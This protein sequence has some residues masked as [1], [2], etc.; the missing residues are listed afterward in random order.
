MRNRIWLNIDDIVLVSKRDFTSKTVDIIHKYSPEHVNK[1]YYL[2]ELNRE[3]DSTDNS[4]GIVFS[5]SNLSTESILN[6]DEI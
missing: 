4:Q 3:T 2:G 5:E 6:I 1:L